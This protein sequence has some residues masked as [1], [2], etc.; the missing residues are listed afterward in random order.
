MAG[1]MMPEEIIDIA[2]RFFRRRENVI[3]GADNFPDRAKGQ[4]IEDYELCCKELWL[5]RCLHSISFKSK[6]VL[7][8]LLPPRMCPILICSSDTLMLMI[9]TVY[10]IDR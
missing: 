10:Y 5:L 4:S 3:T 8:G 9:G 6:K 7:M 1:V 2:T